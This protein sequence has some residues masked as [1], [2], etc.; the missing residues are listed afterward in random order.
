MTTTTARNVNRKKKSRN[1][2]SVQLHRAKYMPKDFDKAE[3]TIKTLSAC[4]H[5]K[6]HSRDTI[7]AMIRAVSLTVVK[8]RA[9]F[10]NSCRFVAKMFGAG[11]NQIRAHCRRWYNEQ[12]IVV[13]D[14][15]RR[16]AGSDKYGDNHHTFCRY[17][18]VCFFC[19]V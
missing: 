12:Q 18:N 6:S 3:E 16:G 9:P 4:K 7:K 19:P 11:V 14:N 13:T 1:A 2:L 8:F 17:G 5:G 10:T 15:S